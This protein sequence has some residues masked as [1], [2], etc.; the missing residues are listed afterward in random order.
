MNFDHTLNN[1]KRISNSSINRIPSNDTNRSTL[2]NL[3]GKSSNINNRSSFEGF[4]RKISKEFKRV[5]GSFERK[6]F[7]SSAGRASS[8]IES[9]LSSNLSKRISSELHRF[10]DILNPS[11]DDVRHRL[12]CKPPQRY[13]R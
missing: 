9:I 3:D 2:K 6:T 8:N 13:E 12:I 1:G 10:S 11:F 7:E 4:E 5:S